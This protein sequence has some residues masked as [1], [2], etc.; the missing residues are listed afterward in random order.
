MI[1]VM[2]RII[3][4]LTLYVSFIVAFAGVY[5]PDNLPVSGNATR[6]CNPDGILSA[7]AVDSLDAM[8]LSLDKK[9]VQCL[10]VAIKNIAGDDPYEFAIGLGRKYG[11][12]GKKSQG[13]VVV[14]ATDDRSYQIVTGDGME[15]FL[16][17]AICRRIENREML[18]H[19]KRGEWD[20]ALLSVVRAVKGIVDGEPELVAEYTA[21][22]DEEVL[23]IVVV[24]VGLILLGFVLL[25][26]CVGLAEIKCPH[27]GKYKLKIAKRKTY[28]DA[29][30]LRHVQTTYVCRH[31]NKATIKDKVEDNDTGNGFGGGVFP[32][33]M[34]MG[35]GSRSGG[36]GGGFGSFGGGSFGGGGAG[37]RF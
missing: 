3:S 37:G 17:D 34:M 28:K 26:L 8:L 32:G 14:L 29:N 33:G 35:G 20:E 11:I 18:P 13:I 36:G 5:T 1:S 22:D 27:C 19:L 30:G 25:A 15:K 2:K 4:I 9:Q 24:T 23:E 10:V 12:G 31:C 16:P 7:S 6:V 21:D